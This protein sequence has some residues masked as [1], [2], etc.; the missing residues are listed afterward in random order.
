M[1]L[2]V[3]G[4]VFDLDFSRVPN[5]EEVGVK[6]HRRDGPMR[7]TT[8]KKY[9]EVQ[10]GVLTFGEKGVI[11]TDWFESYEG[12]VGEVPRDF[13]IAGANFGWHAVDYRVD[14]DD[15]FLTF[16]DGSEVMVNVYGQQAA[17]IVEQYGDAAGLDAN[18]RHYVLRTAWALYS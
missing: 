9:G 5:G 12:K 10:T 8:R 3:L 13:D 6:L 2:L 15:V 7:S 4:Y 18:T 17:Y 11:Y 16:P 1:R 14:R